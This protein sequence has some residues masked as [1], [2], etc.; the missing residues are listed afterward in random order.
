MYK[1]QVDDFAHHPT[2]VKETLKELKKAIKPEK[3]VIVFEPRT[4]SSKRKVFQKD[5][6]KSLSLADVVYIKIPPGLENI[7][8]EERLDI[9]YV[10]EALK[11]ESLKVFLWEKKL[12]YG[13]I[14]GGKFLILFM[15]SAYFE[16]L[17]NLKKI[18]FDSRK[19]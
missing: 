16:E 11:K 17:K 3:T 2:A 18:L 10:I 1:R 9:E 15:S 7:P 8:E 13:I 19:L 14:S 6:I 5:Y 12:K 4:N